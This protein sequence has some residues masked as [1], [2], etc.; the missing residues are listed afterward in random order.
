[1]DKNIVLE[2]KKIALVAHDNRKKDLLAWIGKHKAQL[3]RHKLCGTG[4][5]ASL[6]EDKYDLKVEA[7]KSG[8]L[9]GD[10][11]IG[12]RIAERDIDILIF[13]WDPLEAQPTIQI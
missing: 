7:Y 10:L 5:T 2:K 9:G 3:S 8:P 13:F 4:T 1:M 12:A 11:Q 6:I